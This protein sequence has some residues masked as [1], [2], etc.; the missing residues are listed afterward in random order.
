MNQIRD[1]V[2]STSANK[3][4]YA[5]NDLNESIG[6]FNENIE[7]SI[8]EIQKTYKTLNHKITPNMPVAFLE[9]H[10]TS[11]FKL[12]GKVIVPIRKF[13]ARLFTKWYA[14]TFIN[15]QKHLNNIL[16]N[17]INDV[18]KILNEQ[19]KLIANLT[20]T[21]SENLTKLKELNKI[22]EEISQEVIELNK[23]NT[24]YYSQIQSLEERQ[25]EIGDIEQNVITRVTDIEKEVYAERGIVFNYSS[26]AE[27]FSAHADVVKEIFSQYI[28]YFNDCNLVL[29]VGCGKG[30]F[31]ELLK[32]NNI[33]GVGVDSDPELVAICNNKGL[34]AYSED[35]FKYIEA[36]EDD[37]LEGIFMG[38][39][40]EHFSIPLRIKLLNLL[41]RKLKPNGKL[42]I[43]TPNTTSPFVMH[44]L[45]Y[46]DPT[47]ERPLFPEALK[48]I[49]L[50][51]GFSV[52]NSYLSSPIKEVNLNEFYNHSL[53]LSK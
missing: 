22:N 38:H 27:R 12:F 46:L 25:E 29:D 31:L 30:Y 6:I 23:Q 10:L 52:V 48:H 49:A 51:T 42:I 36:L 7:K 19:N 16:W 45:Y 28:K 3:E 15:Q 47:H 53:I 14:D 39:I 4:Q 33:K 9:P 21:K 13:G 43:E 1:G 35:A 8:L 20:N 32:E 44:N 37:S 26:F 41:Y 2:R 18:I 17:G 24:E 40:I 34:K 50:E 5:Q 11:R